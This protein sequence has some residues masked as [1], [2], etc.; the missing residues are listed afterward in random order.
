MKKINN[1]IYCEECSEI[2]MYKHKIVDDD[3]NYINHIVVDFEKKKEYL[4]NFIQKTQTL[5][6]LQNRFL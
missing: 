4:K 1:F 5:I 6:I 3:N 2:E